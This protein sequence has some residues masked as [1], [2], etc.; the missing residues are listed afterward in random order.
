MKI[1]IITAMQVEHDQI[2]A[3]LPDPRVAPADASLG[4]PALTQGLLGPHRVVLARSGIG[5][6]NAALTASALIAAEHPD[7]VLST[8]C[9][10]GLAASPGVMGVVAAAE[11]VYHDVWCGEGNAY[12]QVQDLP[13]RFAADSRLL[14]VARALA[15]DPEIGTPV[16]VGLTCTGDKF[17]TDRSELSAVQCAFP[18]ALAVDMESTAIAQV[19]YLRGVPFLSFRVLSDCPG[20]EAHWQQYQNF[21][22]TMADR[23]FG[24]TRAF[25]ERIPAS[26]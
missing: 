12:G 15:A 16:A 9:A 7:V 6:V 1:G 8:G 19:C 13:P 17:I 25:L 18:E 22:E 5:K 21:W 24:V 14:A 4:T 3:L 2:V 26:F 23:S 11:T 20:A 10:G